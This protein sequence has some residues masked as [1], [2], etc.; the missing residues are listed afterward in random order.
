[1]AHAPIARCRGRSRGA[2]RRA[3][4]ALLDLAGLRPDPPPVPAR[5][6]SLCR[7]PAPWGRPGSER[8]QPGRGGRGRNGLL[9]RLRPE[10]RPGA[11]DPDERRLRGH[12]APAGLRL[13]P[14][15]G[16]GRG[17]SDRRGG[18]PERRRGHPRAA[19]PSRGAHGGRS[20]RVRRP[21][22][23][24]ALSRLRASPADARPPR[25]GAGR[26]GG[27]AGPARDG[28]GAD[29]GGARAALRCVRGR[30][31][32]AGGPGAGAR[33]VCRLDPHRAGRRLPFGPGDRGSRG[34]DL[35]GAT[36]AAVECRRRGSCRGRT[37]GLGCLLGRGRAR[38]PAGRGRRIRP[39]EVDSVGE[40]AA[41]GARGSRRPHRS[42]RKPEAP[43]RGERFPPRR[44]PSP[45]R[46]VARGEG[47][48]VD[49]AGRTPW[50]CRSARAHP[51]EPLVAAALRSRRQPR[52]RRGRAREAAQACTY[53]FG[54]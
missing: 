49:A 28:R 4:R 30:R 8:R 15:R 1:M 5:G 41:A 25:R 35:G 10:R 50:G 44:P 34:I 26:A 21:A 47:E 17:G 40:G 33:A 43:P 51:L 54:R 14:A 2:R 20:G 45:A 12:A 16:G 24:S 18:R 37:R 48:P 22:R 32:A 31:A 13:R 11:H 9:R 36:P 19:R 39:N 38:T 46:V 6:R 27:R 42:I 53:H 7:R 52:R 23:P 29:S 3:D